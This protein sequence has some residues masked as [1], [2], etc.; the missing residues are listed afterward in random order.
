M[1]EQHTEISRIA[2]ESPSVWSSREVPT[3]HDEITAHSEVY[4]AVVTLIE[5][6]IEQSNEKGFDDLKVRIDD[7]WQLLAE[8]LAAGIYKSGLRDEER[9]ELIDHYLD[10]ILER[11]QRHLGATVIYQ[12]KVEPGVKPWDNEDWAK[13]AAHDYDD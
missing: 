4:G 7:S 12:T 1:N 8:Y 6:G 10:A 13:R 5:A 11:G 9:K 3:G 2:P